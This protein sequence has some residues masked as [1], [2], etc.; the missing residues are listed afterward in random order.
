MIKE[1]DVMLI[2]LIMLLLTHTH[3][4]LSSVDF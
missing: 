2:V 4:R 1:I 3:F